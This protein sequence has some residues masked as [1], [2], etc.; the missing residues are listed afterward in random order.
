[1]NKFKFEWQFMDGKS[2]GKFRPTL[3]MQF[4][5]TT[6]D[7]VLK[8]VGYFLKGCSYD[9]EGEVGIVDEEQGIAEK[10]TEN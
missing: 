9:F 4:E 7:E 10:I 5:A 8:Q 2:S 3:T 1:M 6:I